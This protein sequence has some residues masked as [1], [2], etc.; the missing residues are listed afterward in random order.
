MDVVELLSAK[1]FRLDKLAGQ[2][3]YFSPADGAARRALDTAFQRLTGVAHGQPMALDVKGRTLHVPEAAQGV[4]RFSFAD[5]C[6]QP[7]GA[8]DYLRI[9]HAFHTVLISGVP[10][11]TPP[12]RNEARRFINLIDALYDNRVGLIVSADA[13]PDELYV[14]GDGADLFERTASR[15]IEMRSEAYLLEREGRDA[16]TVVAGPADG[17]PLR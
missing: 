4:A 1:D 7:L 5:L 15:L 10:V 17:H 14:T 8:L 6:A 9:A 3:L 11:L 2:P 12:R 16:V 13:E